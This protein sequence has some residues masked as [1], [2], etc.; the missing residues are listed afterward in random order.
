MADVDKRVKEFQKDGFKSITGGLQQALAKMALGVH[1]AYVTCE[2]YKHKDGTKVGRAFRSGGYL[3]S[4]AEG[5]CPK[6][7]VLQNRIGG[8]SLRWSVQ[9]DQLEEILWKASEE[10][11]PRR[12]TKETVERYSTLHT[13]AKAVLEKKKTSK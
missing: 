3:I 10:D 1:I 5:K 11:A 9:L 13:V 8:N 12:A 7:I 4:V 2:S 6:W